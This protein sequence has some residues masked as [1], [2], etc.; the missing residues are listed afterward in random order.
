MLVLSVGNGVVGFTLDPVMGEFMLTH[1]ELRVPEDTQEFAINASNSRFW[2]APVKRYVDEC[3]AGKTGPRG[4]DFNMRWIAS[5]VA[6]AHRILM[7]RSSAHAERAAHQLAPAHWL[8]VWLQKRG[9]A[10]RALPR[11]A[12]QTR[13]LCPAVCRA[14]L[15]PRLSRPQG[16]HRISKLQG[17]LHV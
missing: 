12:P 14:Q 9:R 16:K 4:K 7:H 3:L 8:G 11:R 10:H 17:D 6:E 2:E 13:Q 1:P 15:V 5:M